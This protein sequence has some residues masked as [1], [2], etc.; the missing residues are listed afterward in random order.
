MDN[1]LNP[2]TNKIT[3]YVD[4]DKNTNLHYAAARGDINTVIKEIDNNNEID[5]INFLGWTPLMVA[6]R[7]GHTKVVQYLLDKHADSTRENNFG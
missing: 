6:T 5:S 2:V 3:L 1:N 7:H 4:E